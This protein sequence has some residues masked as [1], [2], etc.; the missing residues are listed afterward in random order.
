MFYIASLFLTFFGGAD[1][2]IHTIHL[3]IE[4]M[5]VESVE[6]VEKWCEA[7]YG[8]AIDNDIAV[9]N[10]LKNVVKG[11]VRN[12]E[13]FFYFLG[14]SKKLLKMPFFKVFVDKSVKSVCGKVVFGCCKGLFW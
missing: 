14:F 10:R 8:K 3:K 2:I 5:L 13:N 6:T 9:D 12:V 1:R 11:C 4:E 7:L